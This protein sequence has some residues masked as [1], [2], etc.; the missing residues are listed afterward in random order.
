MLVVQ[1]R[2]DPAIHISLGTLRIQIYKEK[3]RMTRMMRTIS[4]FGNSPKG[5]LN[6]TKKNRQM[7]NSFL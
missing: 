2:V 6:I 3:M 7:F 5:M 1:T 4:A